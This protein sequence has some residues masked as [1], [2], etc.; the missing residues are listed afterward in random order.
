MLASGMVVSRGSS[1]VTISFLLSAQSV[2]Q[3]DVYPAVAN[4][5]KDLQADT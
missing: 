4:P 5:P 1:D 2:I 3:T